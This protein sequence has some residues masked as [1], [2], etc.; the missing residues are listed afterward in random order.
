MKA[1]S[2]SCNDNFSIPKCVAIVIVV[3]YIYTC[4]DVLIFNKFELI[5]NITIFIPHRLYKKLKKNMVHK[6]SLRKPDY[7]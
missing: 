1:C 2:L 7:R 5:I 6:C 3:L 4:T